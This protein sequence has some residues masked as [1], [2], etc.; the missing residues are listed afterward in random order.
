MCVAVPGLVVAIGEPTPNSIPAQVSVIDTRRDVDLVMV[1]D[2]A[3]GDY[4]V[5]HSGYA[6][7]IIPKE[8]AI[9]T[10]ALLGIETEDSPI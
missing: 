1:P 3:V 10:M 4:V 6:I 5:I 9:E 7:E 8:R 2:A